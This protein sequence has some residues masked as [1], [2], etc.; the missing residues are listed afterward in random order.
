VL[1][2]LE[3]LAEVSLIDEIIKYAETWRRFRRRFIISAVTSALII[4]LDVFIIIPQNRKNLV[5]LFAALGT[6]SLLTIL[7]IV[8]I[9]AFRCPRCEAAFFFP[10]NRKMVPQCVHCGLPMGSPS[11]SLEEPKN[12]N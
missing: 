5:S 7:L 8:W 10:P 3:N 6:E 2:G 12:S 11:N 9:F 4:V 1:V